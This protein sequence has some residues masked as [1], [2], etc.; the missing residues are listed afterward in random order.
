VDLFEERKQLS[1]E[2]FAQICSL[3]NNGVGK[4]LLTYLEQQII[5]ANNQ[6]VIA[7]PNDAGAIAQLQARVASLGA[8]RQLILAD[9]ARYQEEKDG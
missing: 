5:L 4:S 7:N 1:K 3:Q 2:Q 8:V 6:L 9:P